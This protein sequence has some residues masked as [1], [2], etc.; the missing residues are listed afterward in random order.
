MVALVAIGSI[1]AAA[2]VVF[3]WKL[4][5]PFVRWRLLMHSEVPRGIAQLE[6]FL[7]QFRAPGPGYEPRA[8]NRT[9]H[10]RRR[11]V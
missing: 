4:A 1:V 8:P 6:R 5:R 3:G 9:R 11:G 2:L 10:T 7:A